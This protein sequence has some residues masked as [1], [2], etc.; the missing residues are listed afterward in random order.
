MGYKIVGIV[1]YGH[2]HSATF[3]IINQNTTDLVT[4]KFYICYTTTKYVND[5]IVPTTATAMQ[6]YVQCYKYIKPV[7]QKSQTYLHQAGILG[8][9]TGLITCVPSLATL[10][11]DS[12]PVNHSWI[13]FLQSFAKKSRKNFVPLTTN[14]PAPQLHKRCNVGYWT[15]PPSKVC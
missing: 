7:S 9:C 1:S 10:I 8:T 5:F 3:V 13:F 15:T 4:R 14:A 12:F 11:Y 6:Q 2:S